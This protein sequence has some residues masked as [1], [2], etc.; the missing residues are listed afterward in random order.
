M[1]E[2][3]A[4]PAEP[5]D[6]PMAEDDATPPA[7]DNALLFKEIEPRVCDPPGF[8]ALRDAPP[9]AE[10]ED[11]PMAEDDAPPPPEDDEPSTEAAAAA[12]E[13]PLRAIRSACSDLQAQLGAM[14]ASFDDLDAAPLT[15]SL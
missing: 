1:A 2:D 10:P 8:F 3:A 6:A 7:E 12:E 4:P 13:S 15:L 5:E 9:P 11:A 14:I